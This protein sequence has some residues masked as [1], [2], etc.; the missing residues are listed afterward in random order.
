MSLN[1]HY[2]QH[3]AFEDLGSMKTA[4]ESKGHHLS[5]SH[6]YKDPIFP[7]LDE[8]DWLIVM[9]GPMGIDQQSLYPWLAD[10]KAFIQSAIKAGKTVLGI[11]LGAQLIASA[12]GARVYK[13]KYKEIG[14]FDIKRAPGI[15]DSLLSNLIPEKLHAFHWHGDTFDLP[16]N[17]IAFGES[18]A[19]PHQGF[20]LN[21]RVVA[22]QFHLETTYESASRL[23]ENCKDDIDGS[24]YVQSEQMM[25]AQPGKFREIN[26]LMLGVLSALENRWA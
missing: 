11:C 20:I 9:G 4:L 18:E 5:A 16:Q 6:L 26:A 15:D 25:L 3:V 24:Q 22:F 17:A 21:D 23:I 14:W 7:G 19:C 13:N 10:E 8:F 12:L 2:L 1:I